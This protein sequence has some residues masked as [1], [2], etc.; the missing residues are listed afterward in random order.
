MNASDTTAQQSGEG[1]SQQAT[2]EGTRVTPPPKLTE[3]DIEQ[4]LDSI[5]DA[6]TGQV[7]SDGKLKHYLH[8]I[9]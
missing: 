9:S 7:T 4:T 5:P 2:E 6:A 8:T 1:A 3:Q